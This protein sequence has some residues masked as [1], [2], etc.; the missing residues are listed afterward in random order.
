MLFLQRNDQ[1]RITITWNIRE[2]TGTDQGVSK[3]MTNKW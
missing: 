1:I 3:L 2:K